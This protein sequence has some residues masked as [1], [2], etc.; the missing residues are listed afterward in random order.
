MI[1]DASLHAYALA[2]QNLGAKQKQVLEAVRFFP[3]A[4]IARALSWPV[5]RVTSRM[6]GVSGRNTPPNSAGCT[7]RQDS[8]AV[9]RCGLIRRGRPI[10]GV[11]SSV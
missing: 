6:L 2:T 9:D 5:N 8:S 10:E 3:D 4:A 7:D 11:I 1:Q